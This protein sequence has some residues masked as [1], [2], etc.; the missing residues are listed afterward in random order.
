MSPRSGGLSPYTPALRHPVL[1][2]LLPAMAL[3]AVGDGMSYVAVSWLAVQLA[4]AGSTAIWVGVCSA[5]AVLPGVAVTLARP[6]AFGAASA[7][8]VA[9]GNA[10]LHAVALGAIPLASW[11]GALDVRVLT[12]LIVLSAPL[13]VWGAAA[14]SMIIATTLPDPHRVAGSATVSTLAQVGVLAGAPL[15][16][17]TGAQAAVTASAVA[18]LALGA[19]AALALLLTSTR[20]RSA[21]KTREERPDRL[22]VSAHGARV[23]TN[24]PAEG[25]NARASRGPS[26][27]SSTSRPP[28]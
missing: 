24:G 23:A 12:V 5:A 7:F 26:W 4:P 28:A 6:G 9:R 21:T 3:S 13:T 1:R 17:T 16:A 8:A 14:R 18:T 15:V 10:L 19:G 2:P 22:S 11:A 27:I 20:A 25:R